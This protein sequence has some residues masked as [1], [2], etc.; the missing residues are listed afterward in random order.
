VPYTWPEDD[1]G[2]KRQKPNRFLLIIAVVMC[3]SFGIV[4]LVR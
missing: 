4:F 3:I 2:M 1:L